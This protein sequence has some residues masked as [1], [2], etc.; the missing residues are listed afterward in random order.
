MA[1]R[2]S[3]LVWNRALGPGLLVWE[4][5]GGWMRYEGADGRVH[6]WQW[7]EVTTDVPTEALVWRFGDHGWCESYGEAGRRITISTRDGQRL[8]FRDAPPE[9]GA[10]VQGELFS[11]AVE[12]P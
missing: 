6:R 9:P 1:D 3:R 10:Y 4:E 5:P 2:G 11:L 7:S 8:S 12:A